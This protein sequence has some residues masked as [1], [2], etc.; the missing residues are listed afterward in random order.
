MDLT[1][2]VDE[3]EGYVEALKLGEPVLFAA[4]SSFCSGI[5]VGVVFGAHADAY[6]ALTDKR[7]LGSDKKPEM[8]KFHSTGINWVEKRRTENYIGIILSF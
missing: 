8:F 7:M 2:Y 6:I 4:M 5:I 3:F 1:D